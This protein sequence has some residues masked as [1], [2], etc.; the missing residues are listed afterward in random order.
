MAWALRNGGTLARQRVA[1]ALAYRLLRLAAEM[2][3]G[4]DDVV[5]RDC[6]EF[7]AL[8]FVSVCPSSGTADAAVCRGPEQYRPMLVTIGCTTEP[9]ER[10]N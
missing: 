10:C 7:L 3:T 8:R 1:L 2:V 6:G 4:G 9:I 5:V